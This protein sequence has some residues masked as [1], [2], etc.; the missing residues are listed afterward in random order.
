[1]K[2]LKDGCKNIAGGHLKSTYVRGVSIKF[3]DRLARINDHAIC[4]IYKLIWTL[5]YTSLSILCKFFDELVRLRW[6]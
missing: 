1:M 6:H 3:L 4:S 5:F 2:L